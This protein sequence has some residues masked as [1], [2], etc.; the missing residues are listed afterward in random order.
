M[1]SYPINRK[2]IMISKLAI[3][4][5]LTFITVILSNIFV[6]GIFI[7][8]DSYFSILPNSFAVDQLIQEGINLVPLAIA[9]AGISLILYTSE[10]VNVRANYYCFVYYRCANRN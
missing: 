4:A 10:C 1:F 2:K 8:I 7:G 5:I 3:T 6:V 9:T